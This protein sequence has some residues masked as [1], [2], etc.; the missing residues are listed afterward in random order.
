MNEKVEMSKH[1]YAH[2]Q[3]IY[4]SLGEQLTS[5]IDV[6]RRTYASTSKYRKK[7]QS[8]AA[9]LTPFPMTRSRHCCKVFRHINTTHYMELS[10]EHF[11][12]EKKAPSRRQVQLIVDMIVYTSSC[13]G[14]LLKCV[15]HMF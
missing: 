3:P 7:L 12:T 4:K 9:K 13:G 8:R 1:T 11:S 10:K 6:A 5:V 15:T 14:T 2:T